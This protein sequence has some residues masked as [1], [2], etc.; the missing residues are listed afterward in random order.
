MMRIIG[1]MDQRELP[2]LG[3]LPCFEAAARHGSFKAAAREL[4][5][6]PSAVSQQIKA[7]EQ[8][9]GVQLFAR[10]QRAVSLTTV[11][12]EYLHDVQLLLTDIDTATR[13]LRRRGAVNVLRI[14]TTPFAASEFFI[15]RMTDFR[16]CFPDVELRIES[17]THLVD[18][19]A[20]E[21]DA[22]LRIG[23][24]HASGTRS[25]EVGPL[26]AATVCAPR[27]AA[28]V[29]SLDDVLQHPL[30]ELRNVAD[31]GW[32]TVSS[33]VRPG[34]IL[35][36]D[37]YLET[38][39]AAEQGL[40]FAYGVFPLTTE[41]V[42]SGRLAVPL[43]RRTPLRESLQ[44]VCRGSERRPLLDA[45]GDWLREQYRTLPPLDPEG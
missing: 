9:L 4:H 7:L 37:T 29:R 27:L 12:R 23:S 35:T 6:T 45:I 18:F 1:V 26:L 22:A 20:G 43:A 10:S 3:L 8:A 17:S 41:W 30:I 16:R 24:G 34:Q 19:N 42:R 32:G 11:G 5:L 36:F 2:P 44:W 14:S 28:G 38:M 25:I 15:P 40:G 31:R 39:R 33:R 21:F 13:R